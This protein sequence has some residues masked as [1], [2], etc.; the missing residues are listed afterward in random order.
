MLASQYGLRRFDW[1]M[2]QF[3]RILKA[4]GRSSACHSIRHRWKG[5]LETRFPLPAGRGST[6]RKWDGFS[7]LCFKAGD[8]VE[9]RAKSGKPALL[10]ENGSSARRFGCTLICARWRARHR[11]GGSFSFDALQ[12][13]LHPAESR[14]ESSRER[15]RLRLSRSISCWQRTGL[16]LWMNRCGAENIRTATA[17]FWGMVAIKSPPARIRC[18]A[19]ERDRRRGRNRRVRCRRDH[20]SRCPSGRPDVRV[21]RGILET[22]GPAGIDLGGRHN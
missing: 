7:C 22:A 18:N 14:C 19:R 20:T 3:R 6:S 21:G 17:S 8:R 15:R 13:R 2:S 11:D 5:R 4:P 12:M 1:S 9:M 10:P 16:G